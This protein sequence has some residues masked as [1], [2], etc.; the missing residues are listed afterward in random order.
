[1]SFLSRI[2][3][4]TSPRTS[5]APLYAQIVAEGRDPAWYR[6]GQAPDTLDGRFDIIAALLALV[7]LRLEDAG[8]HAETVLLTE[9]FIADM[10]GSLRQLGIG[11]LMVGKQVG[12]MMSALGG[13]LAAFRDAGALDA[14]VARNVFH[15]APPS[16]RAVRIVAARLEAFRDRLAALPI[17]QLLAGERP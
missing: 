15:D 7:L 10:D 6:D 2:F 17:A 4:E 8:R 9:T 11:D 14:A 3:G 1:M 16:D 5:L 12:R 13:R